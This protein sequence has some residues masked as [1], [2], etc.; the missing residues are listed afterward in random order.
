MIQFRGPVKRGTPAS[1]WFAS[2]GSFFGA[3][4]KNLPRSNACPKCR[5]DATKRAHRQGL[6]ERLLSLFFVYPYRCRKCGHR[7]V[8]FRNPGGSPST[9]SNKT[10]PAQKRRRELLLYGLGIVL[11]LALLSFLVRERNEPSSSDGN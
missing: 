6:R 7:F 5:S 9:S 3:E 2:P 4:I 10:N 1:G 8:R 11:F